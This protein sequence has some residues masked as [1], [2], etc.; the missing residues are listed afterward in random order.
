MK[1]RLKKTGNV[2]LLAIVLV[3]ISNVA[4]LGQRKNV[5]NDTE[6]IRKVVLLNS[7]PWEVLMNRDGEIL[8]KL[9][10]LPNY[11]SNKNIGYDK[12]KM[13]SY[14][15]NASNR[16]DEITDADIKG[17]GDIYFLPGSA[18]LRKKQINILNKLAEILKRD[19][20]KKIVLLGF[21]NEPVMIA[22]VLGKRRMD[23]VITYLK[24]KGVDIA[25]QVERGSTAKGV[26]NKIAYI[27]KD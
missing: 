23:A 24:I 16:K 12:R 25:N 19:R 14:V 2:F 3:F 8:A 26:N 15:Q 5:K 22:S 4:L 1:R 11:F 7:T 27:F 21:T 13:Y 17:F 18:L 6:T 9:H 20:N 10:Y